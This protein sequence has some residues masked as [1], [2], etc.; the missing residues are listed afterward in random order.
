MHSQ[1]Y[2]FAL[3]ADKIHREWLY[4]APQESESLLYERR[5]E[6]NLYLYDIPENFM[7]AKDFSKDKVLPANTLLLAVLAKFTDTPARRVM[8]WI[9]NTFNVIPSP[10]EEAYESMPLS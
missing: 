10:D 6:E 8:E 1:T 7:I 9:G 5:F 3:D 4:F 2:G